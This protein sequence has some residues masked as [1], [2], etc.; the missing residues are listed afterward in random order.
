MTSAQNRFCSTPL[1]ATYTVPYGGPTAA[2]AAGAGPGASSTTTTTSSSP[3]KP[4]V[5]WD[6]VTHVVSDQKIQSTYEKPLAPGSTTKVTTA[7]GRIVTTTTTTTVTTTIATTEILHPGEPGYEV[8]LERQRAQT[9]A[10]PKER[11]Q[12]EK[13]YRESRAWSSGDRAAHDCFHQHHRCAG[14]PVKPVFAN[15]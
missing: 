7:F 14:K 8:S 1:A 3:L 12:I 4:T 13:R 2:A 6:C 15:A 5:N 9:E 10:S 11:E